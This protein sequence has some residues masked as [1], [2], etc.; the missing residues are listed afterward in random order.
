[1]RYLEACWCFSYLLVALHHLQICDAS[2]KLNNR[3][4][5]GYD[6]AMTSRFLDY[7]SPVPLRTQRNI[8]TKILYDLKRGHKNEEAESEV[9]ETSALVPDATADESPETSSLVTTG[10]S[11][12]TERSVAYKKLPEDSPVSPESGHNRRDFISDLP[13]PK[14]EAIDGILSQAVS[15]I[16]SK[17]VPGIPSTARSNETFTVT[18]VGSVAP[19]NASVKDNIPPAASVTTTS[20]NA[21]ATAK[22]EINSYATKRKDVVER[23]NVLG[24]DGAL[25]NNVINDTLL[26]QIDAVS[27]TA[28]GDAVTPEKDVVNNFERPI[29]QPQSDTPNDVGRVWLPKDDDVS[30]TRR[31]KSSDQESQ[32]ENDD[33]PPASDKGNRRSSSYFYDPSTLNPVGLTNEVDDDDNFV[34]SL[35]QVQGRAEKHNLNLFQVSYFFYENILFKILLR[36]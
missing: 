25:A 9:K 15:Q 19:V 2:D 33:E 30:A 6:R 27:L 34:P 31:E 23:K 8:I 12:I 4:A 13:K 10:E 29:D 28:S 5:T 36:L 14:K 20:L 11:F 3:V 7:R 32:F 26:R 16:F 21:T 24:V 1:M 18:E 22:S 17:V 35:R